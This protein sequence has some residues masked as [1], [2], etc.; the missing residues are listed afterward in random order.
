MYAINVG[1]SEPHRPNDSFFLPALTCQR[2]IPSRTTSSTHPY[3]SIDAGS[4]SLPVFHDTQVPVLTLFCSACTTKLRWDE[5]FYTSLDSG[6]DVRILLRNTERGNGRDTRIL[7]IEG[8]KL[9]IFG[10]FVCR[11]MDG[12]SG[13]GRLGRALE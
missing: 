11:N 12:G 9:L 4:L 3:S 1:Y 7:I 5:S 10:I 8:L 2:S 6:V 13:K